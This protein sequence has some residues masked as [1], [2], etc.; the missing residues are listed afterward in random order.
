MP[1]YDRSGPMSEGP[2]SGRGQGLCRAGQVESEDLAA[3][4]FDRFAGRGRAAGFGGR[5]G[6]RRNM[7]GR[8][9]R[10]MGGRFAGTSDFSDRDALK[11][12]VDELRRSL[13]AVEQQLAGLGRDNE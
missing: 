11:S 3:P 8:Y 6:F 9:G 7:G 5:G 12:E 10:G 13:A 2:M 1:G 4:V